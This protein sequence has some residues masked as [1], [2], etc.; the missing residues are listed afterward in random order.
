MSKY[1]SPT[2]AN[3]AATPLNETDAISKTHPWVNL[4]AQRPLRAVSWSSMES[5]I[6]AEAKASLEDAC[7]K[8]GLNVEE[9]LEKLLAADCK[10]AQSSAPDWTTASLT[11][12]IDH[13]IDHIPSSRC[14][15]SYRALRS[16]RRR[17]PEFMVTITLK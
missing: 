14:G 10:E 4:V 12:L 1:A 11:D 9:I 7:R 17:W 6:A 13:I 3:S 8:K 5:I 15:R 16:W 2:H